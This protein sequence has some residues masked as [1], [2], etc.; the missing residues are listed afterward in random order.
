ME[1]EFINLKKRKTLRSIPPQ[2]FFWGKNSLGN[3]ETVRVPE[4]VL[5]PRPPVVVPEEHDGGG[6]ND[7]ED[8]DRADDRDYHSFRRY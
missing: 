1:F 8:D 7:G 4:F 5:G 3:R 6:H 2:L